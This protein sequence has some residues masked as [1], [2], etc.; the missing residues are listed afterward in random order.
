ML[1]QSDKLTIRAYQGVN[2]TTWTPPPF[3]GNETIPELYAFHAEKSAEHPAIV[4]DEGSDVRELHFKELYA[5]IRRAAHFVQQYVHPSPPS[6]ASDASD[7]PPV[8][9]ILTVSGV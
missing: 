5:A 4:Y 9:G 3:Y 2:S 1:V 7:K 8:V 6:L